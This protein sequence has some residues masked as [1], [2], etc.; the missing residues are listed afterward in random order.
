MTLVEE[1]RQIK[2]DYF[3]PSTVILDETDDNFI[4]KGVVYFKADSYFPEYIEYDI[5]LTINKEFPKFTPELKELRGEIRDHIYINKC[6]LGTNVRLRYI[7]SKNK[8]FHFFFRNAVLGYLLTMYSYYKT[9]NYICGD[10]K[11]GID[12]IYEDYRDIFILMDEIEIADFLVQLKQKVESGAFISTM[13]CPCGHRENFSDCHGKFYT[14]DDFL[15]DLE[16]FR[17]KG[18]CKFPNS[19]LLDFV[20]R[21]NWYK[22]KTDIPR[23]TYT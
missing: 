17:K 2:Q 15:K 1:I 7:I 20:P 3:R 6:C 18:I 11:H 5:Q 14:T 9:G 12:G 21:N 8:S 19:K 23:R 4:L 10:R 13:K 22:N 16:T